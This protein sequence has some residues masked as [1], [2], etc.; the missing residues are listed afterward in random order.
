MKID[1]SKKYVVNGAALTMMLSELDED[2]RARIERG[3]KEVGEG[4]E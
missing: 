1:M 2:M 4:S 3:I